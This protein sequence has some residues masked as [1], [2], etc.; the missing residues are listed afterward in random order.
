MRAGARSQARLARLAAVAIVAPFL[1][2]SPAFA[3]ATTR[4]EPATQQDGAA[5]WVVPVG[6]A[7]GAVLGFGAGASIGLI[8]YDCEGGLSCLGGGNAW[9]TGGLVGAGIGAGVGLVTTAIVLLASTP[10]ETPAA[11]AVV[12]A[13][14]ELAYAGVRVAL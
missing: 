3:Q 8:T 12:V 4:P 7:G 2:A 5:W 14:P 10:A 9:L 1:V 6:G 11:T 13:H